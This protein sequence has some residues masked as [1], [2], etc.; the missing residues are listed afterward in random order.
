MVKEIFKIDII[1]IQKNI[2]NF[3]EKFN[4]NMFGNYKRPAINISQ[5][6]N[7][8]LINVDMPGLE[9]DDINLKIHHNSLEVLGEK[10]RKILKKGEE[11]ISYKGFRANIGL[12]THIDIDNLKAV[13]KNNNLKVMIPKM[14]TKLGSKINIE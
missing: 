7:Y 12:P 3:F 6:S 10:K 2:N 4:E 13:Y 9:R 1:K 14:K 8:V 11:N 5:N